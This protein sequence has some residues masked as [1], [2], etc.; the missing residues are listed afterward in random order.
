MK[1]GSTPPTYKKK[2]VE[3]MPKVVVQ[4]SKGNFIE[5]RSVPEGTYIAVLKAIK[6]GSI[7][8][9]GE[10]RP[11]FRWFFTILDRKFEKEDGSV[12]YATV[13]GLTSQ[14]VTT[15]SKAYKWFSRLTGYYPKEGEEIELEDAIGSIAQVVVKNKKSASGR[16][17]SRVDDVVALPE[18]M[19]KYAEQLKAEWEREEGIEPEDEEVEDYDEEVEEEEEEDE[20]EE[21]IQPKKPE[22]KK[23]K[24]KKRA[25]LD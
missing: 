13:E 20:E 5:T 16:V 21:V 25:K 6:E 4:A 8:F 3:A 23:K 1:R 10:E 24:K 15:R 17:Y 11:I 18:G 14:I 7:T 22:P 19:K 9:K 2:E 12:E